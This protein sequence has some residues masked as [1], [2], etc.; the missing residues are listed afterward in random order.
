MP[1][2][3]LVSFCTLMCLPLAAGTVK[4]ELTGAGSQTVVFASSGEDNFTKAAQ[5]SSG[6]FQFDSA[7]WNCSGAA[8]SGPRIFVIGA[9][10]A[11]A[12]AEAADVCKDG[13]VRDVKIE[14]EAPAE[15]KVVVWLKKAS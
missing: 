8:A 15:V 1:R 9:T 5:V 11:A 7:L 14:L 4:V 2:A 10:H 3:W 13:N 6:V 12:F